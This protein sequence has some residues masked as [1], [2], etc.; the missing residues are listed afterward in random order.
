MTVTTEVTP[1]DISLASIDDNPFQTRLTY[2]PEKISALA[3]SIAEHG[4]L[5][6]PL[7]RRMSD[8]RIQLAFG[9]SR[10]RAY[11]LLSVQTM[12]LI[13]R[14]LDD[15]TMALHAWTE[16]KDR[17]D[18]TAYEE[19]MAIQKYM[20][21]FGWSQKQ[22]AEHLKLN[23]STISN[24][25]RLLK[26]PE[27]VLKQ[28]LAGTISERQAIALLPLTELPAVTLQK[29]SESRSGYGG[30]SR[31]PYDSAATTDSAQ[32][33]REVEFAIEGHT[34]PLAKAVW[35][36]IPVTNVGAHA[37][38][39]G[40]CP[41]RI[42]ASD[43]CPDTDCADRKEKAYQ[44]QLASAAAESVGLRPGPKPEHGEYDSLSGNNLAAMMDQSLMRNCGN[45][46][47]VQNY[48]AIGLTIPRHKDCYVVC[49]HGRSKRCGC[50]M[51]LANT[52]DPK[53]SEQA[54]KKLDKVRM[55]EELIQPAKAALTRNLAKPNADLICLLVRN[56][57][58]NNATKKIK[59]VQNL[60]QAYALLAEALVE[61]QVMYNLDNGDYKGGK[62]G[63]ADLFARAGLPAPWETQD[64]K[65][66]VKPAPAAPDL[67]ANAPQLQPH[68]ITGDITLDRD[69][70]AALS[71]LG[72]SV[73]WHQGRILVTFAD[74]SDASG[75][76][77]T[78]YDSAE[79]RTWLPTAEL[80]AGVASSE[81]RAGI[82][83]GITIVQGSM[84]DRH[85]VAHLVAQIAILE[86][87][88]TVLPMQVVELVSTL[89]GM[90]DA[91]DDA[92]YEELMFDLQRLQQRQQTEAA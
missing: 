45:L 20:H 16:N 18:L 79:L 40:E 28:V 27:G 50:K 56:T 13:I 19:A 49:A 48:Y 74:G 10:Y 37:A 55:K 52:G 75:I 59:D 63:L 69:L 8:N 78:F 17:S 36:D 26:L 29:M 38:V 65:S 67:R 66:D 9:H 21:K 3:T 22:V 54:R 57:G 68:A 7:A 73:R 88:A 83:P 34:R 64:V 42:K 58:A 14:E 33:R 1:E 71:A 41:I 86:V 30:R 51:A 91:L 32:L 2:D 70:Q 84:A 85:E 87:S 25:L 60:E 46:V 61:R 89:E 77:Q 47:V 11:L 44:V 23:P 43:R 62:Q 80:V 81:G 24:K 92:T 76:G 4:L 82:L 15:Q 5:Q 31:N 6:V 90:P 35:R 12:P 39:C 72:L 53:T